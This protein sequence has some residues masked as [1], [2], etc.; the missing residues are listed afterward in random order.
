MNVYMWLSSGLAIFLYVPLVIQI[1]EK[2]GAGQNLLTWILWGCLD[3]VAAASIISQRGNS[4][5]VLMYVAGC[6]I[7]SIFIWRFGEKGKWTW[8]ETTTL[9][10]VFVSLVVWCVSGDKMATIASTVGV[11]IAGIPQFIDAYR[12]PRAI[13]LAIYTGYV[14]A[15]C[16]GIAAGA[17]WSV[18]ERLYPAAMTILGLGYVACAARRFLRSQNQTLSI[19]GESSS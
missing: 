17:D 10:F 5:L 19:P 7:T 14:V 16:L 4:F 6:V 9:A 3:A 13:P 18:K 2:A 15:N 8:L 11:V 1:K 12:K